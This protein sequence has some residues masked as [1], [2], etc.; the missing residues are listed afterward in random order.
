MGDKEE[1]DVASDGEKP[2]IPVVCADQGC[3]GTDRKECRKYSYPKKDDNRKVKG[4][5][6]KG[7]APL[8]EKPPDPQDKDGRE[9]DSH[10]TYLCQVNAVYWNKEDEWYNKDDRKI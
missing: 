2:L 9:K 3:V 4:A 6:N 5:M 7:I 10:Y 8:F 1:E